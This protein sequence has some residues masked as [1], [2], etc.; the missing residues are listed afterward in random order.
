MRDANGSRNLLFYGNSYS[1]GHGT[2]PGIVED[3]A[4]TA[5]LP[6]PNV[7]ARL[8]GGQNLF[9]HLTNPT[10]AAAI[11]T[12]LPL[13]EEWDFVVMQGFSTEATSIGDPAAFLANAQ[14]IFANVR[15][16]SPSAQA[17]FY[18]T[19][20]R[21]RGHSFYPGSFAGP[22]QMHRE[23]EDSYTQAEALL[24]AN[25]GAGS[26]RRAAVGETV[27]LLDFAPFLYDPDL[28]HP[29]APLSLLAGLCLFQELYRVPVCSLQPDFGGTSPLANWL[30][31]YSVDSAQWS[32]LVGLASRVAADVARPY[33][34]S[35]DDLFLRSGPA[36]GLLTGCPELAVT[37][38]DL[39]NLSLQSPNET[40]VGANAF[41]Y[42]QR[43]PS[44]GALAPHPVLSGLYLDPT[45]AMTLLSLGT[46]ASGQ[47]SAGFTVPAVLSGARFLVQGYAAATSYQTGLGFTTTDAHVLEL[48]P[49]A[50]QLVPLA[51]L[52]P[53]A[54]GSR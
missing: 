34:G 22:L 8:V 51:P 39:V 33:P 3:L 47:Q 32:R 5:G 11:T 25:F 28:S 30:T 24:N 21:A 1:M 38:G 18:Q 26:A 9:Y 19:W 15:A 12:A 52:A 35:G 2:V 53:P 10:Q 17:C 42:L 43:R 48:A 27:A 45:Q 41:L 4:D 13:G 46:L 20:A 23:I 31:S 14:A 37:G 49:G 29:E 54:P 16:H 7:T 50:V 36:G 40:F 6:D 44:G